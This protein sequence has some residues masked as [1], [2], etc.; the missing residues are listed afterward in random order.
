MR[1]CQREAIRCMNAQKSR[2]DSFFPRSAD[3]RIRRARKRLGPARAQNR[4][5]IYV[6]SNQRASAAGY[7]PAGKRRRPHRRP[8]LPGRRLSPSFSFRASGSF[9]LP[10]HR[11]PSAA[12]RGEEWGRG[13]ADTRKVFHPH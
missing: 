7:L 12:P 5:S 2:A 3:R 1:S 11:A 4:L 6:N 8:A 9:P 13:D 10:G